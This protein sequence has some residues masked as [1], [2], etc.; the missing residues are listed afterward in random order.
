[1]LTV[2]SAEW[3]QRRQMLGG[4][5]VPSSPV[6]RREVARWQ[7]VASIV[8]CTGE[9]V[10]QGTLSPVILWFN[11]KQIVIVSLVVFLDSTLR[12]CYQ[13]KVH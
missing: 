6:A 13:K 7:S 3:G 2:Y 4:R 10:R 12:L 11:L 8:V 9:A 5:N 1:M